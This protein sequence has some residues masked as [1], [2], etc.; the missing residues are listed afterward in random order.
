M[1]GRDYH[2]LHHENG[3]FRFEPR[4]RGEGSLLWHPYDGA[5]PVRMLFDGRYAHGPEWYRRFRYEE[6]LRRGLDDGEDL[7]SPGTFSWPID[8]AATLV[9]TADVD[10]PFDVH[11]LR[12]RERSRRA[13]FTSP[14]E[15]AAD[16]FVVRRGTGSTIVAGYPWFTEWGRDTFIAI[17]GICLA[18]GRVQEAKQ[19]LLEWSG[20]VSEGMLPNRFADKG[21]APSTTRWTRPSGTSSPSA[22]CWT[23]TVRSSVRRNELGCFAR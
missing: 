16:A 2:A 8:S 4:A 3:S 17:R 15:R 6:E 14:L 22:S 20:A 1:S 5:P 11:A 13:K 23:N 18:T 21:E 10:A 12:D 19:I 7:A 9:T